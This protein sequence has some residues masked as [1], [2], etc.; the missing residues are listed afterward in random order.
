M[1]RALL[2]F[3][4]KEWR[5]Y[6]SYRLALILN[7]TS[8]AFGVFTFFF[9]GRMFADSSNPYLARFGGNYFPYVLVGIASSNLLVSMLNG[10]A[11]N[12]QREQ[13]TGTLE[14]ILVCPIPEAVALLGL[15]LWNLFLSL[16][17]GVGYLAGGYLLA[18]LPLAIMPILK[19][20]IVFVLSAGTFLGLGGTAAAFI[21][22]FKRGNPISWIFS[23]LSILLGSVY[24]PLEILPRAVQHL[25]RLLPLVHATEGMRM[26]LLENAPLAVLGPKLLIL[27]LFSVIFAPL[28]IISLKYA[29]WRVREAGTLSHQ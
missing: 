12:L 1:I 5:L 25:G 26:A 17:T 6:R 10:L 24:F 13:D 20:L 29:L 22:Y 11:M 23:S 3:P 14:A 28:A 2:A 8:V 7:L 4:A 16:L 19:A 21:L 27:F 9:V 15:V 18:M